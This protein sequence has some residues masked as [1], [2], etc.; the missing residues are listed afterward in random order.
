MTPTPHTMVSSMHQ[1]TWE[2]IKMI[3]VYVLFTTLGLHGIY[4]R[5][6]L[7]EERGRLV[8]KKFNVDWHVETWELTDD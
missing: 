3:E 2:M 8:A 5:K 1:L 7:A 6:E 4:K